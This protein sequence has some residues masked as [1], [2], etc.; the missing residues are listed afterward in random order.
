MEIGTVEGAVNTETFHFEAHKDVEKFDF[1]AVKA[2]TD[3]AEW[4]LAQIAEVEKKPLKDSDKVDDAY[5]TVA[6]ANIIGYRNK[7]L[8]KKPRSV[9]EPDS[10]VYRA[11]Q[12]LISDTL[13]LDQNGLYMGLLLTDPDI[14]IYMDPEDLY[15]HFAV[16]AKTG[17]GK[18]VSGETPILLADGTTKPIREIF[19][20]HAAR[21]V[22]E[23]E[24]ETLVRLDDVQVQSLDGNRQIGSSEAVFGYRKEEDTVITIT[25]E[26][27]RE[28]TVSEEHPLLTA[29]EDISFTEAAD[30]E[31]GHHIAVPRTTDATEDATLSLSP[32]LQA[33]SSAIVAERQEKQRQYQTAMEIRSQG[34]G[35]TTISAMTGA[36]QGT[37]ENWIYH[38]DQP[39]ATVQEGLAV[40]ETGKQ[41]ELPGDLTS[42]SEFLALL[43]AEGA[44]QYTHYY[45]A[46]F[47]NSDQQLLDRFTMLT[48]QLFGLE[49]RPMEGGVYIDSNALK[50]FLDDIG[51]RTCQRSATKQIPNI[52]M[53]APQAAKKAF[54]QAYFDCDG[55]M[56]DHEA[57][58]ISASREIINRL[59]Y[60][61]LEFG[62]VA[63]LRETA[64]TAT[65]SE[66]TEDTYYELVISGRNDLELF[67]ERIGFG[68]ERKQAKLQSY[69]DGR[70]RNT[71]VDIIPVDGDAIRN[72]REKQGLSQ[73]ELA[74][75]ID[76]SQMSI[77]R[78]E[79][80]NRRPS[81]QALKRL[82]DQLG[83]D[84]YHRL[85][86]AD[87]SWDRIA[88]IER[89][90]NPGTH[91]YDLTVRDDHTFIGGYG[92]IINHNSYATAVLIEELLEKDYP[93]VI[94][95]PHDEYHSLTEPNV[96]E[97]EDM[98]QYDVEPRDFPT[99]EYS[100]NT[101]LNHRA[102][103]L[104][105]SSKNMDAKEIQQ[106]VPTNLT[107]SQLGVLYTALKELKK[108]ESYTLD[109]VIETC[110]DQD[111]KAKW[112]LINMLETVR[113]SGLFAEQPTD[114]DQLIEQ[115]TAT[116]INLRGVDPEMQ[117]TV[118]Y[119]LSKELFER[120]K[121]GKL[122][123]FFMVMEEAHNFVPEK[124]MGKAICSD[125]LRKIASEGRKFGMG[126]GVISQRPANVAK[127]ILSQCNTQLIMRVTNPN[128]L[129]AISR[130]FE[131]VTSEV[132]DSI[133]SLPPGVGLLLGKEYPIMTDIR[134]RKSKH[135]GG[136]KDVSEEEGIEKGG[137]TREEES[138]TAKAEQTDVEIGHDDQPEEVDE[139]DERV[140]EAFTAAMSQDDLPQDMD[141]P[142]TAY[143]PIY[144]VKTPVGR[145]AI[146]A[147]DGE[148]TARDLN[149]TDQADSVLD[150]LKEH[151]MTRAE[152]SELTSL[153]EE[154]VGKILDRLRDY[155]LVEKDDEYYS[156]TGVDLFSHQVEEV[157]AAGDRVIDVKLSEDEA[158]QIAKDELG[159]EAK[160]VRLVYYPYFKTGNRVFDAVLEKEV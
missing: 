47:S 148:V 90:D 96:L 125:I 78:Y 100:T 117:E 45:R 105:F 27:G 130:S 75:E 120:R 35:P 72:A 70:E 15:K 99:Q 1:V 37:V 104:T 28:I 124:G 10:I 89:K 5:K 80:E 88:S 126:I 101:E 67:A 144:I 58:V 95:D 32:D 66:H 147:E 84:Q 115:G 18:C 118:V 82:A 46:I 87:I 77:S 39:A 43:I 73:R 50:A 132:E 112:N 22:H 74:S 4:L 119:K 44:E 20:E 155:R 116:I 156:Y 23:N 26:S 153:D 69:L 113:D 65:N 86:T 48:E 154:T 97:D 152:L 93:V 57:C 142:V 76:M 135:G 102:E 13:G 79:N 110:M 11:D 61:L 131:G 129:S 122:E 123:P 29:E 17:A 25:T 38:G 52:V 63:R 107:N 138:L 3:E 149:L 59:A 49:A 146:D 139:P 128:D 160:N 31:E 143:Y 14:K 91:V 51:Y 41:I 141:E 150:G 53:R 98:Q 60:L 33:R 56:D 159:K 158:R 24:D 157:D 111:S 145:L 83:L 121:R 92:G 64:K 55:W 36:K 40:S 94:I 108:R 34:N 2:N 21:T 151:D 42:L 109:D 81:R 7:G 134:V 68:L 71:N 127:N 137:E 85:S 62:I 19:E 140:I 133:T 114:L 30:L 9:I 16:L 8:L 54:L 106:V 136:T 6:S 12:D 103:Q